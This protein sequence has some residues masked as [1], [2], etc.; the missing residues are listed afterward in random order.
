MINAQKLVRRDGVRQLITGGI[1]IAIM[2]FF[3]ISIFFTGFSSMLISSVYSIAFGLAGIAVFNRGIKDYRDASQSKGFIQDLS[4]DSYHTLPQRMYIGHKAADVFHA[5]LYDMNG[6]VYSEIKPK[7]KYDIKIFRPFISLFNGGSL[8]P[9]TYQMYDKAGD[10]SYKIDKKGGFTWRGYVQYPDGA[11]VAYTSHEKL[12]GTG[13]SVF[14]Y[15][16]G[17][18]TQWKA[19]GDRVIGHLEVKDEEGLLWAVIKRDAVPYEA[20]EQFDRMPGYLVEWKKRED[21]PHSL[22]A[23]LFLVQTNTA[24]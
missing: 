3:L 1:L 12:K 7:E 13:K 9:A 16:E 11:Y 17:E 10:P 14:C 21:I 15:I 8:I 23:F 6:E 18:K 24:G 20:A 22:V 4:T 2:M 5:S 19:E